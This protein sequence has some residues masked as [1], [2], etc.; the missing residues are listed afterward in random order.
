[1]DDFGKRAQDLKARAG[2]TRKAA[3]RDLGASGDPRALG[4]LLAALE[5]DDPEVREEAARALGRLRDARCREAL[6]KLLSDEKSAVQRAARE[7]LSALDRPRPSAALASGPL[8]PAQPGS[9]RAAR[10]ALLA[11]ALDGTGAIWQPTPF[12]YEVEVPLGARKQRVR[13][14]L[15]NVDEDGDRTILVQTSC[16]PASDKN[17]RWALKLNTKIGY[18]H[19]GVRRVGTGEEFVYCHALLE[20]TTQ[21]EELRKAVIG[22]ATRGDWVEKQVTGGKDES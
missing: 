17:Y 14:I 13:V 7:A 6:E 4:P 10:D 21:P 3:A 15:E 19:L 2:L 20:A 1:M 12:G 18:G 11:E 8:L 22:V 5:D 16:G 9:P